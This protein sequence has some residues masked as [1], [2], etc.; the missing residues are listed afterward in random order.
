MRA[1]QKDKHIS[2]PSI[3][4]LDGAPF[5]MGLPAGH[6]ASSLSALT[7]FKLLSCTCDSTTNNINM[8]IYWLIFTKYHFLY[9]FE[10]IYHKTF[11]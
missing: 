7:I 11:C 8:S 10:T 1:L 4:G 3:G 2:S 9:L 5:I 6:R